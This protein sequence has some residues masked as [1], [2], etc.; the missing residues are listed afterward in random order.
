MILINIR[1]MQINRRMNEEGRRPGARSRRAMR[2]QSIF[3]AAL[4]LIVTACNAAGTN[5]SLPSSA[6]GMG[7]TGAPDGM[8]PN[9]DHTSVLKLLTV[10][11]TI[12]STVDP[13]NGDVN[14]YGL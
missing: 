8:Q 1:C 10:Q 3:A 5:Q 12:G 14:P 9:V 4:A 2:I 7:V 11:Q 6:A 13:T